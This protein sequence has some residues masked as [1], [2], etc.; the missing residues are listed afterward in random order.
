MNTDPA[1]QI[2]QGSA[3]FGDIASGQSA[4]NAV[5]PFSF[6]VSGEAVLHNSTFHVQIS[7]DG[8]YAHVDSSITLLIG[9]ADMLLVD[10]DCGEGY[11]QYY[12]EPLQA[13]DIYPAV[14]E[15]K[16][17]GA[18]S[19]TELQR[20]PIVIW[21]TGDDRGST[22]T[23]AEQAALAGYLDNGGSCLLTGQDI[24]YDLAGEGSVA[25]SVFYAEYL[26]ARF[27]ADTSSGSSVMGVPGETIASGLFVHFSGAEP[28]ASNQSAPD[29]IA[30]LS[31]A[32]T[33]LKYIPS[34]VAAGLCYEDAASGERLVYLSFGFEGIAGPQ[35]FSGLELLERII[36]WLRGPVADE[37]TA[38]HTYIPDGYALRQNYPNPFSTGGGSRISG[39]PKT[40]IAYTIPQSEHVT[41]IVYNILGEEVAVLEDAKRPA[42]S[43]TL[44]L[45]GR[46]LSNGIY[47]YTMKAGPFVA[48]KKCILVR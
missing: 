8:G 7:G 35:P 42:G 41:V 48:S 14:W 26:H 36:D 25:D 46:T 40:K 15:V 43:F 24:G 37:K 5:N 20:Y 21:F 9:S 18:P 23:V 16:T 6:S 28:S 45:D 13:L 33:I 12:L 38:P 32:K 29:E 17:A 1:V 30:S 2:L 44:T 34:T 39:F 10:D 4:S 19:A 3:D 31:P 47:I 27:V 22:L 11:E